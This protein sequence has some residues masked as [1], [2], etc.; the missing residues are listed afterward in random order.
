MGRPANAF[1][2][3]HVMARQNSW[4][5]TLNSYA[6]GGL[7]ICAVREDML[8]FDK[9][10]IKFTARKQPGFNSLTEKAKILYDDSVVCDNEG[11]FRPSDK[12]RLVNYSQLVEI[13]TSTDE[14]LL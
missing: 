11:R 4:L 10:A 13:L 7:L 2:I 6:I 14:S 1:E 12:A 9:Q 8:L 5:P 3:M